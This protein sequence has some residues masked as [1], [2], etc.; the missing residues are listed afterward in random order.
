MIELF[1]TYRNYSSIFIPFKIVSKDDS[2]AIV[3]VFI[4]PDDVGYW[5]TD[6]LWFFKNDLDK[7]FTEVK[8][9]H[10]YTGVI[11]ILFERLVLEQL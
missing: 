5:R 10:R 8:D 11:K 2:Q 7:D 4:K 6:D 1:K 9:D 3:H